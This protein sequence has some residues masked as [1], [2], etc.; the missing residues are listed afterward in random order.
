MNYFEKL[1]DNYAL[2]NNNPLE[3]YSERT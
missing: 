3:I 1:H 2:S